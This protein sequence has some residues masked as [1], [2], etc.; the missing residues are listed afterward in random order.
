MYV[1]ANLEPM[2]LAATTLFFVVAY[3]RSERILI[4]SLRI[5]YISRRL[6]LN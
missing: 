6:K 1:V 5:L 3:W 2:K 4:I